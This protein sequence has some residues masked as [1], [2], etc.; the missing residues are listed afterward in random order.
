MML[1]TSCDWA[2]VMYGLKYNV[3]QSILHGPHT[4]HS[5]SLG[6]LLPAHLAYAVASCQVT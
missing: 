3:Y 5:A 1:I 6:S 2:A 4:P